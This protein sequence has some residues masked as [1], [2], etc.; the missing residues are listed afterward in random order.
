[1]QLM[2]TLLI[3]VSYSATAMLLWW[4]VEECG[5]TPVAG[6]VARWK[7]IATV[8]IRPGMILISPIVTL[9]PVPVSVRAGAMGR[10]TVKR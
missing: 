9:L 7:R 1:M 8:R 5:V 4:I 10:G 2:N 3:V 6:I